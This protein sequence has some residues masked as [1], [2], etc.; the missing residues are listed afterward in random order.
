MEPASWRRPRKKSLRAA[1]RCRRRRPWPWGPG[2]RGNSAV[3]SRTRRSREGCALPPSQGCPSRPCRCRWL[4][5]RQPVDDLARPGA[6][7]DAL[8]PRFADAVDGVEADRQKRGVEG[9]LDLVGE[10]GRGEIGE[11]G[12]KNTPT[13]EGLLHAGVPADRTLRYESGVGHESAGDEAELLDEARVGRRR[14]RR[15]NAAARRSCRASA[16]AR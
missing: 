16:R 2:C 12:H 14:A 9:E 13:P 15:S 3:A 8:T 11:V 6:R 4:S 5:G 10:R 7:F 1:G